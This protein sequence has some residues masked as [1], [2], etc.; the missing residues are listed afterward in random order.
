M[1]KKILVAELEVKTTDLRILELD[2]HK[3]DLYTYPLALKNFRMM[4]YNGEGDI[5]SFGLAPSPTRSSLEGYNQAELERQG[6]VSMR[7]I[8]YF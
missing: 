5:K 1:V 6:W 3:W 2:V 8:L 4:F 7:K